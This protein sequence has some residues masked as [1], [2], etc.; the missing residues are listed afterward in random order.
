MGLQRDFAKVSN[1]SEQQKNEQKYRATNI[2]NKLILSFKQ[3]IHCKTHRQHLRKFEKCFTGS[4][5]KKVMFKLLVH[6]E[7]LTENVTRQKTMK[8]LQKFLDNHITEDVYGKWLGETF[9]ASSKLYRFSYGMKS[10]TLNE[11]CLIRMADLKYSDPRSGNRTIRSTLRSPQGNT[12]RLKSILLLLKDIPSP[13]KTHGVSK[14]KDKK[15]SVSS[16]P[17]TP[18]LRK[19]FSTFSTVIRQSELLS[20]PTF[21][22]SG[23]KRYAS[24]D[25]SATNPDKRLRTL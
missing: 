18:P 3:A 4:E 15:R 7:S 11:K 2:W 1:N 10:N 6:C 5:A 13:H 12:P 22:R 16:S 23:V 17:P 14:K 19:R 9:T 25:S 8:L 20:S 24:T 21:I